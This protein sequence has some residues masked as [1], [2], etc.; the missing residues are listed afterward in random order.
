M[1]PP[2]RNTDFVFGALLLALVAQ[3]GTANARCP[4]D[5]V[6][7][8]T[9]TTQ[10]DTAVII[11]HVCTPVAQMTQADLGEIVTRDLED[12]ARRWHWSAEKLR[13]FDEALHALALPEDYAD[14]QGSLPSWAVI[15]AHSQ[16]P[17]LAREAAVGVGPDLWRAGVG[18]QTTYDDCAIFALANAA[19]L[20]YSV[21][22][23]DAM[24]VLRNEDWRD[25][26]EHDDPEEVLKK[27]GLNAGETLFLAEALG[28]VHVVTPNSFDATLTAGQPI[29]VDVRI[30]LDGN[31]NPFDHEM[32]LTK[33]FQHQGAPWFELVD[34][35][36]QGAL[37][38]VYVS[39]PQLHAMIRENGIV[40]THTPGATPALL[41]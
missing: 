40:Y 37:R 2:L 17:V 7:T 11:H 8:S 36:K 1:K 10:T 30:G 41:R 35:S 13:R 22:A 24:A 15:L 31:G 3:T 9:Y 33:S 21:V 38:Q 14:S 25:A 20:P 18:T 4:K 23:S 34:S 26:P 5:T 6:E 28:Q 39:E 27:Q 32:V 12:L 29:M 16:N 19:G